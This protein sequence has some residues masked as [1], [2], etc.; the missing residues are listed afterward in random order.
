MIAV[1]CVQRSQPSLQPVA[2]H[3]PA[4]SFPYRE[5]DP[6]MVCP[7]VRHDKREQ[8]MTEELSTSK[9]GIEVNRPLQ[10]FGSREPSVAGHEIARRLTPLKRPVAPGLSVVAGQAP[11][12][13]ALRTFCV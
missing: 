11:A 4:D 2:Q 9:D 10:P 13:R 1:L 5:S 7:T 6:S 12:C 3:R 8:G